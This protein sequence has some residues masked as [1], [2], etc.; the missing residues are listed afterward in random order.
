MVFC[1]VCGQMIHRG[2]KDWTYVQAPYEPQG[3]M[4]EKCKNSIRGMPFEFEKMGWFMGE[5]EYK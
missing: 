1:P 3:F 2:A 4:H 5:T